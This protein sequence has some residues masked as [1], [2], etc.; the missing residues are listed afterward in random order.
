MLDLLKWSS[1][2]SSRGSGRGT[3]AVE[4]GGREWL[5]NWGKWS[6]QGHTVSGT[7][8]QPGPRHPG[9]CTHPAFLGVR[10]SHR[11]SMVHSRIL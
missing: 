11:K 5:R 2:A 7:E 4:V 10:G 3:G 1:S 8:P 9:S 6:A